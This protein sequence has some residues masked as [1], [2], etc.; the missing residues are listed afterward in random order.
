[1]S[2]LSFDCS[3]AGV[4][5]EGICCYASSMVTEYMISA[6]SEHYTFMVHLVGSAGHLQEVENMVMAIPCQ[7]HVGAWMAL[8]SVCRI[9]GNVEMAERVAVRILE[10]EPE[11]VPGYVLFSNIYAAGGNR[12]LCENV[13]AKR[14]ENGVKEQLGHIWIEVNNEVHIF[15]VDDQDHPKMIEIHAELQRLSRL[16]QDTWY[17]CALYKI[18][19]LGC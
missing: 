1:L 17:V 12:H 14:K 18:C 16:M 5:D 19:S 15:V 6:K 11:N 9:H 13:E 8:L 10:L 3:H 4:V 7:P 2:S